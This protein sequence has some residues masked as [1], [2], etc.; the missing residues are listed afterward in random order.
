MV[1][2]DSFHDNLCLWRCLFIVVLGLTEAQM[3]LGVSQET[4]FEAGTF[5]ALISGTLEASKNISTEESLWP[6]GLVSGF[7]NQ[8]FNKMKQLCGVWRVSLQRG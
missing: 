3:P 1:A 6:N 4:I 5:Q 2:L 7:M 8:N